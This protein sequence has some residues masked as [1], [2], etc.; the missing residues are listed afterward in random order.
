MDSGNTLKIES[1]KFYRTRGGRKV[2][3]MEPIPHGHNWRG[4]CES[5]RATW[6]YHQSGKWGVF[7]GQM[8][9]EMRSP[10]EIAR[11]LIAEWS[12]APDLTAIREPFGLLD[13]ATQDALRAHGGAV[14]IFSD[15]GW[16]DW[17]NPMWTPSM[18]Y[19]VKP[20]PPAPKVETVTL[21][22]CAEYN[23]VPYREHHC[24]NLSTHR[25][26]FDLID[27]EPDCAS[28]RMVKL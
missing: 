5:E 6:G 7:T 12:D 9:D 13:A 20:T 15:G 24:G 26:T 22:T 17:L 1:G 10:H 14:Q 4:A 2:G 11:D 8:P 28:I 19:R 21:L 27:G 25:I 18:T 16:T 23:W 3:P